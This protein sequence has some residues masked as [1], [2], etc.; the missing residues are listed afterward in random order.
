MRI[1]AIFNEKDERQ[2]TYIKFLTRTFPEMINEENPE[3]YYVIGGDG[4]MLHVHSSFSDSN[5]PFF[6]KG[7]G[8]LNFIMN[9]FDDNFEIVDGLLT[10]EI[11]PDI[12]ET[13]KL[14]VIVTKKDGT[15]IEKLSINDVIIGNNIMDWHHFTIN[16]EEKSFNQMNLKGTG[17]CISTPLGSTAYNLNNRGMALPLDGNLISMTGISCDHRVNEILKPQDINITLSRSRHEPFVYV[18]GVA[19]AIPLEMGDTVQ[20][21]KTTKVFKLAFLN[22]EDFFSKRMELVQKKI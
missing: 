13:L 10:D 4:A 18:D 16:S 8:T 2:H 19:T 9:N 6:G 1:K 21:K 15:V 5:I 11:T 3:M 22:K 20:I 12:V 14:G 17:I 7:F